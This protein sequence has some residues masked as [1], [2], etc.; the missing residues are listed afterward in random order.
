MMRLALDAESDA[1]AVGDK[2]GCAW[3]LAAALWRYRHGGPGLR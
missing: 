2:A 3:T 1:E